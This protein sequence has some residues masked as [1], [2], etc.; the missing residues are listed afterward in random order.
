MMT[1]PEG[2]T[3]W[4]VLG[5]VVLVVAGSIVGSWAAGVVG[6]LLERTQLD[7]GIRRLL[8]RF[9]RPLVVFV[10]V[11]VALEWLDVDLTAVLVLLAAAAIAVALAVQPTL[12]HFVSGGVLLTLRP[13][14]EGERVTCAGLE[15]KVVEQGSLAVTLE[16]DDGTIATI[17]NSVVFSAPILNHVRAGRRRV[18]VVVDLPAG[19][20]PIALRAEIEQILGREPRLLLTPPADVAVTSG[21]DGARM[22][23]RAWVD[24]ASFEAVRS[25]LAEAV[26]ALVKVHVAERVAGRR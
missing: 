7:P 25:S 22:T 21:R 19:S 24:A 26:H 11:V 13:Y 2:W 18:E 4:H 3:F 1:V 15:G 16:Q 9:V 12:A 5:A 20:D 6:V 14:R 10:A 8:T 17:P 23:T